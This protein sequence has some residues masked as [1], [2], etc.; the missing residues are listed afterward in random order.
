MPL[1]R[2]ASKASLTAKL[3]YDFIGNIALKRQTG[4]QRS[5]ETAGEYLSR[6]AMQLFVRKHTQTNFYIPWVLKDHLH[7]ALVSSIAFVSR[8]VRLR[9][10]TKGA[11]NTSTILNPPGMATG[12]DASSDIQLVSLPVGAFDLILDHNLSSLA[13]LQATRHIPQTF[14]WIVMQSKEFTRRLG[15]VHIMLVSDMTTE[16]VRLCRGSV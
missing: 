9:K 8:L 4:M 7:V 15:K 13:D 16:A 10:A 6:K 12:T 5:G 3:S 2:G 14:N 11:T 1:L